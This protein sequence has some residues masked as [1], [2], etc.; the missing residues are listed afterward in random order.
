MYTM[1]KLISHTELN[2]LDNSPTNQLAVSQL[3]NLIQ[4][5]VN[6]LTVNF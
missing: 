6:V 5:S 3:V 2:S 4:V 1:S